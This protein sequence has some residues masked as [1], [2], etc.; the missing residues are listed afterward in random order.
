MLDRFSKLT[1]AQQDNIIKIAAM[2][3]AMGPLI[4]TLAAGIQVVTGLGKALIWLNANPVSLVILAVAALAL[5]L[6]V[7]YRRS[8]T[9]RNIVDAAFRFIGRTIAAVVHA[10]LTLFRALLN[11]WTNVIEAILRTTARFVRIFKPE[12]ADAMERA[13]DKVRDFRTSANREIDKIDKS[14]K[15]TFNANTKPATD[16]IKG[17]EKVIEALKDR[18]WGPIK[19]PVEVLIG[20]MSDGYGLVGTGGG[21][22]LGVSPTAAVARAYTALGRPGDVISGLRPGARTLSGALS[23]HARG[24]ALDITPI[25]SIAHAIRGIFGGR[26]IELITPWPHLNLW[27]GRP[28]R[29]SAAVQAQH[30]GGNAHIHWAMAL[31][32]YIRRQATLPMVTFAETAPEIVAPEPI[33]REIVRTESGGGMSQMQFGQLARIIARQPA[34]RPNV[35]VHVHLDGDEVLTKRVHVIL[36]HRDEAD[37]MHSYMAG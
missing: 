37:D 18:H 30:S 23:Y 27:G 17:L 8:E 14:V 9:F 35:M 33:L 15:T 26:T 19:I 29:Y 7:A 32:A 10:V 3:A 22:L 36:D 1:P 4:K 24:R 31:G 34:Y 25:V 16:K 5:G 13:A 20:K 2:A 21:S 12:W 28:H 11:V 6:V